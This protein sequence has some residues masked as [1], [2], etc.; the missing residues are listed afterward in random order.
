MKVYRGVNKMHAQEDSWFI[1]MFKIS[2]AVAFAFYICVYR[3]LGLLACFLF[4]VRHS[5]VPEYA[6][7]Y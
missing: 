6:S 5:I 1:C 4:F 7:H 2:V 3:L